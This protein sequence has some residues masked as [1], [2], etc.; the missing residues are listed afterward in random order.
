MEKFWKQK[1]YPIAMK[2]VL[3][4]FQVSDLFKIGIWA[5]HFY[6][7]NSDWCQKPNKKC[8]AGEHLILSV[9]SQGYLLR[10]RIVWILI[11]FNVEMRP[12][13][14]KDLPLTVILQ[15]LDNVSSFVRVTLPVTVS[16]QTIRASVISTEMF[17]P[18]TTQMLVTRLGQ[19]Q[20]QGS[21]KVKSRK[22]KIC[23]NKTKSLKSRENKRC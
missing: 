3:E 4:Y 20:C 2:D 13:K 5:E 1:K 14:Q 15:H 22:F 6:V 18:M 9:D 23:K 7:G 16:H 8:G 12:E 10:F 11:F 21:A 19:S 17:Q